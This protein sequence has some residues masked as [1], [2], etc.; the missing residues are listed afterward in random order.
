MPLT[1]IAIRNAKPREKPFKLTDADGMFLLVNPN[2]SR[3]WRLKYRVD[4]REKLLALGAYPETT[5]AQA[6]T[7]RAA[8]KATMR[9][10]KDPGAQRKLDKLTKKAVAGNTFRAL[11]ED[12]L[13]QEAKRG[14]AEITINKKRWL[15]E[16]TLP[17]IGDRPISEITPPELLAVLRKLEARGHLE[18]AR[19][20][21]SVCSQ[22]FR[23]AIFEGKAERDPTADLRGAL[24]AP[25]VTHHAA[26]VEPKA[27]GAL[28][29]ALDGYQGSPITLAALRLAPLVFLRPGELRQAE[30]VEFYFEGER[31][32]WRLPS[33]KMK[34]RRPHRVPLARQALAIIESLRPLTGSGR[35]VFPSIRTLVR[36]MSENTLNAGLRRLGYA[37]D[38][39]T[40]HGFR[41]IATV[42]LNEAKRWHPDAVERQMAHL[43][44]NAVRQAYNSQAEY[45]DERVEMMQWW[46]DYLDK[47]RDGEAISASPPAGV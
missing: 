22:V 28:L 39:M 21:R 42:R 23:Y 12:W 24:I 17:D 34:M 32:E 1:E 6:R 30:W 38:E 8:A 2:G 9:D 5:L 25:T 10:G 33:H 35:Y 44:K 13:M 7:A 31:P 18:S 14:H 46:A 4:G 43:D 29:R 11:A 47:L 27:V 37:G 20:M 41:S 3:L 19:R 45:W 16:M 36:P 40:S 15:I 26:I